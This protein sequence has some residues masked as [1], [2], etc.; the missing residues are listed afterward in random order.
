MVSYSSAN[1]NRQAKLGISAVIVPVM[2]VLWKTRNAY[3]FHGQKPIKDSV[4]HL[5]NEE[6]TQSSG[7][8]LFLRSETLLWTLY[9]T[10]LTCQ[11]LA[12]GAN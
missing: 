1:L 4:I 9:S 8:K 7:Q 3:I 10:A 11:S 2:F 6:A 5:F 12:K